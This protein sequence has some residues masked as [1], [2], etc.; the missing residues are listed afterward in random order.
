MK[1]TSIRFQLGTFFAATLFLGAAW[2]A[3]SQPVQMSGVPITTAIESLARLSGVNFIIDPKLFAPTGASSGNAVSEPTVTFSWTNT[4][5]SSALARLL[6]EHGLVMVQDKFTTVTL[7]TGTNHVANVVD[8]SLLDSTNATTQTT[9]APVP[10][11]QFQDVPLDEAL[12]NL[13][14]HD[15]L[16][17]VLDGKVST[18]VDPADQSFHITPTV[19]LRWENLTAKK[20]IVAL[21]EIYDLAI[22]KDATTGVTRIKPKD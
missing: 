21:C 19:S 7:I 12:K 10:V 13:I 16:N 9:N 6:K 15:H 1:T 18:Y 20:T 3:N 11:F 17:V 14:E 22:V 5:A 2:T 8:A 4:S